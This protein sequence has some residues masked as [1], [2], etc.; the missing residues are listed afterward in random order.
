MVGWTMVCIKQRLS[1]KK[2]LLVFYDKQ[3]VTLINKVTVIAKFNHFNAIQYKQQK[4]HNITQ[5][6][7]YTVKTCCQ[8]W[9][10]YLYYIMTDSSIIMPIIGTEDLLQKP[11]QSRNQIFKHSRYARTLITCTWVIINNQQWSKLTSSRSQVSSISV[12]QVYTS[13]QF[14]AHFM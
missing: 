9:L 7:D 3:T 1:N 4:S 2:Q 12:E 5:Y 8:I 10:R 13:I 11:R 14:S 6:H